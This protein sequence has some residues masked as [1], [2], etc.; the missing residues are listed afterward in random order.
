MK[1]DKNKKSTEAPMK[2]VNPKD[3]DFQRTPE[4]T[5]NVDESENEE[6]RRERN[7]QNRK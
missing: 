6:R 2:S 1:N 3:R 5:D 4:E 7:K